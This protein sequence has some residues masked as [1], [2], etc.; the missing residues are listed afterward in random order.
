MA[1]DTKISA[2]GGETGGPAETA[3]QTT[4]FLRKDGLEANPFAGVP[5]VLPPLPAGVVALLSGAGGSSTTPGGSLLQQYTPSGLQVILPGTMPGS[6]LTAASTLA[7]FTSAAAIASGS[8]PANDPVAGATYVLK[9]SGVVSSTGTPTYT[10]AMN[11][12]STAIAALGAITTGSGI[13][14]QSW[15]AELTLQFYSAVLAAG[16]LKLSWG[17]STS[18]DAASLYE[19]SSG[20]AAAGD[21]TTAIT[22]VSTAAK[23]L[24]LT[25]ACSASNAA[26]TISA[27]TCYAQRVA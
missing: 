27:L 25:V 4:L 13:A 11:Y 26:N 12:G 17:T 2:L 5:A 1:T 6:L 8:I 19:A 7:S 22:V 14:F 15:E 23:T 21:G 10:F 9:C 3:D 18:T 24:N 16:N 20:N